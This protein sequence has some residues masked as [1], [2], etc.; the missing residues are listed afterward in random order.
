MG[1][2]HLGDLYT[3]MIGKA[4]DG[5]GWVQGET[6]GAGKESGRGPQRKIKNKIFQAFKT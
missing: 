5:G 1:D 6:H 2:G 4:N 3:I